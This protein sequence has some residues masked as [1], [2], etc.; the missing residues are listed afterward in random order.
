MLTGHGLIV[1]LGVE[2]EVTFIPSHSEPCMKVSLHTAPSLIALLLGIQ[3][4]RYLVP[5]YHR[6]NGDVIAEDF[7]IHPFR[8][9]F[10]V[11]CGLL[12]LNPMV[13]NT[14]RTR[15]IYLFVF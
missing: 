4:W 13:R 5:S 14:V 9:S 10:E 7:C 6:D 11:Q 15:Y 8:L 2:S 3:R 1:R 12:Q